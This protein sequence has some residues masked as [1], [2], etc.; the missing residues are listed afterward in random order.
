[1]FLQYIIKVEGR[2][3]IYIYSSSLMD[4]LMILQKILQNMFGNS[5]V[6][7]L[8]IICERKVQLCLMFGFPVWSVAV[9]CLEMIDASCLSSG[10]DFLRRV[11]FLPFLADCF[12]NFCSVCSEI[13]VGT[14]VTVSVTLFLM[15]EMG[16]WGLSQYIIDWAY[17]RKTNYSTLYIYMYSEN[18]HKISTAKYD[19]CTHIK[20]HGMLTMQATLTL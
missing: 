4:W 2:H 18:K 17:C 16:L 14:D 7:V 6:P 1:M 19:L 13:M 5:N 8:E 20:P 11:V 15:Q 3:K 9:L 12:W 10:T